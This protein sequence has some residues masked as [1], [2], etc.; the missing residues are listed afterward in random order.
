MEYQK[1]QT[2]ERQ[3]LMYLD[4]LLKNGLKFMISQVVLKI[5]I[6]QVNKQ[7]LKHQC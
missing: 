6:N 7:D 1:L 2:F 3:H 5:D 4:L